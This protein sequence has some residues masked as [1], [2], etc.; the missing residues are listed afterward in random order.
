MDEPDNVH[1]TLN[2]KKSESARGKSHMPTRTEQVYSEMQL[3]YDVFNR[4][5]FGNLNNFLV[6]LFT[7]R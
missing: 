2:H 7:S 6:D 3:A 1:F 4:D 5:L